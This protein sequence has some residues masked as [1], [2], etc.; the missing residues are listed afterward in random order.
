MTA[1]LKS[2]IKELAMHIRSFFVSF[3]VAVALAGVVA[4]MARA[5]EGQWNIVERVP[6]NLKF[7][8]IKDRVPLC[9][10]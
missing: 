1:I 4:P 10:Q 3:F 2:A 6:P 8:A 5:Q 7:R 9:N